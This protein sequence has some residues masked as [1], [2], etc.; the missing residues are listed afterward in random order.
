[1]EPIGNLAAALAKAQGAMT[2]AIIDGKAEVT[3]KSG[4]KY[5]YTYSSLTSV[6][7]AIRK[8]LSDNGLAIFQ[9]TDDDSGS[10]ILLTTLAHESGES[11]TSRLVVCRVGTPAQEMGS[12]L[13]YARRYSISALVG[14][15]TDDDD[16][17]AKATEH[18][19]KQP[20]EKK[21]VEPTSQASAKNEQV[22]S[23]LPFRA[24]VQG[25]V[26][27]A[28]QTA[29]QVW[30]ANNDGVIVTSVVKASF[31]KL[32]AQGL[33]GRELMD[34]W[35]AKVSDKAATFAESQASETDTTEDDRADIDAHG[36]EVPY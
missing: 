29:P 15:V 5:S 2:P 24:S 32:Q 4:G 11:V 14:V 31:R 26:E 35:I 20:T 16:D 17:G 25:A 34:A 30:P 18:Q 13:T 6:W 7:S 22:A 8:P 23:E 9:T 27:W 28:C 3:M 21:P 10:V 12:A 33:T 36:H 1:M 19:R